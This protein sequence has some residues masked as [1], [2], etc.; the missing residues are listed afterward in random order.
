MTMHV[1]FKRDKDGYKAEWSGYVERT[2]ARRF[3]EDGV[4]MPYN[5][6]VEKT[7]AAAQAQ[8][9]VKVEEVEVEKKQKPKK[10]FKRELTN[11]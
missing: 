3:C 4:A 9:E 6:Y 7:K 8:V 2:L 5:E 1:Y 10:K 11:G